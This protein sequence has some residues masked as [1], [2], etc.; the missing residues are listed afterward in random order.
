M[1]YRKYCGKLGGRLVSLAISPKNCISII[2]LYL[3]TEIENVVF[4]FAINDAINHAAP[5]LLSVYA[6]S[7]VFGECFQIYTLIRHINAV[8]RP[9]KKEAWVCNSSC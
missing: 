7:P 4:K 9:I 2:T 1:T 8:T 3:P 6:N 5:F